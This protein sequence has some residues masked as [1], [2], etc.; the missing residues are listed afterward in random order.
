MSKN[1]SG[2]FFGFK[3]K[4]GFRAVEGF[5]TDG[6]SGCSR[7]PSTEDKSKR[8]LSSPYPPAAPYAGMTQ[9]GAVLMGLCGLATP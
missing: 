3:I 9:Q 5:H 2:Y 4:G 1:N 8:H 6:S 7:L